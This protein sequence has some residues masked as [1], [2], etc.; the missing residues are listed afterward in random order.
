M[1]ERREAVTTP[2]PRGRNPF[3]ESDVE[4][5]ADGIARYLGPSAVA[6]PHAARQ[7][8]ARRRRQ[9][10]VLEVGGRPLTY[11]E[12]WDGSARVA[13]GLQRGRRRARG[14]RGDPARRT[15]STGCSRSSARRCSGPRS[16]R[17][18]PAS[19]RR[20]SPTSSATPAPPSRSSPARSLPDRR[21]HRGRGPRAG[22]ARRDLLHQRH[23][24]LPEGRE[25]H[26]RQLPD[27][28][29]RTPSAVLR[30]TARRARASPRWCRS[31]CSTS[32]AA[33]A[34]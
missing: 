20:R 25:D 30:P 2:S 28:L 22:R 33:T 14:S 29:A 7:R 23:H 10:R 4:R 8:R 18:T 13:G 24:R 32:P 9:S 1:S 27:Q 12:L 17:S 26:A 21:A 16:S 11:Q 34:S 6:G 19:P 31:P 5:G 3:D 15:G